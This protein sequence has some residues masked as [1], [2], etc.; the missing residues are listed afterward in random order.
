MSYHSRLT[1]SGTTE[2]HRLEKRAASRDRWRIKP[3][4]KDSSIEHR[5]HYF[6]PSQLSE[7]PNSSGTD[8]LSRSLSKTAVVRRRRPHFDHALQLLDPI[9]ETNGPETQTQVYPPRSRTVLRL[10]VMSAV[11]AAVMLVSSDLQIESGNDSRT[12]VPSRHATRLA[13]DEVE[14]GSS[15]ELNMAKPS[16]NVA[17]ATIVTDENVTE[18]AA[19]VGLTNFDQPDFK[20]SGIDTEATTSLDEQTGLESASLSP[21]HLPRS[22]AGVA[23]SL[24]APSSSQQL[25]HTD[26]LPYELVS[27]AGQGGPKIELA[28]VQS[29][30]SKRIAT[31]S[32]F[33]VQIAAVRDEAD[34]QRAW[35]RSLTD[36]GAILAGLKPYFE[37]AETSNGVF[38]RIQAGTFRSLSEAHHFCAR[39]R[40]RD[41]TCFVVAL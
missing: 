15:V 1:S 41:V 17:I 38:Y 12:G 36:H 14:A 20:S 7:L 28:A 9:E 31:A 26:I 2:Q 32:H 5:Q 37:R 16:N 34:A 25:N 11:A 4:T 29:S 30:V 13:G 22:H 40:D 23:T 33:R 19:I 21:K 18:H 6:A 27:T 10:T 3:R 24:P 39:L 35:A 8:R